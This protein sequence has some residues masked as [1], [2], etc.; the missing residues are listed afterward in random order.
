MELL[1]DTRIIL[2]WLNDDKMLNDDHRSL[3]GD[4]ENLCYI[5][6]ASIWE[7]SIKSSM[8]KLTISA[9]YLDVL[10]EQGFQ[11]LQVSWKHCKAIKNLPNIHG[12]PFD[13]MLIAQAQSEALVLLSVDEHVKKYDVK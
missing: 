10:K 3:I 6:A 7:I 5:S 1:L 8:G 13:R 2:W 4:S 12:D 9:N 11:E